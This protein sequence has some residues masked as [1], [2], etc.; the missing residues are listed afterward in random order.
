MPPE[1]QPVVLTAA[2]KLMLNMSFKS[3]SDLYEFFKLRKSSFRFIFRES[4]LAAQEGV[5]L[6]VPDSGAK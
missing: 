1:S 3:H 5:P 2:D 4:H 6:P